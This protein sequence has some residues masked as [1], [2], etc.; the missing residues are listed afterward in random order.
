MMVKDQAL[1]SKRDKI[2]IYWMHKFVS[3]TMLNNFMGEIV[4][5][6]GID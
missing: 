2:I 4:E 3:R 6:I 1:S 5:G